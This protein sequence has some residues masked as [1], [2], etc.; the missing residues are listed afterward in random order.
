MRRS[1]VPLLLALALVAVGLVAIRPAVA[2]GQG[3]PAV[4]PGILRLPARDPIRTPAAPLSGTTAVELGHAAADDGA[5][6][7]VLII[8]EDRE[9]PTRA[10]LLALGEQLF[11][12]G[13]VP[14][15]DPLLP[16]S[17][18]APPLALPA[19]RVMR[20]QTLSA[21]GIGERMGSWRL[22]LRLMLAEPRLPDGHPLAP[23]QPAPL[24]AAPIVATVL[25]EARPAAGS[26]PGWPERWAATGRAI[27]QAFLA[28]VTPPGGPRLP[29]RHPGVAWETPL[30]LPP[31]TPELRWQGAF[32]HALLRGW[33]GRIAGRTVRAR[34]GSEEGAEQPLRRLLARGGW[35]PLAPEGGWQLWQRLKDGERQHFGLRDDG[36]GWTAT[37][38]YPHPDPAALIERLGRAAAAGDAGAR[39]RLQRLASAPGLDAALRARLA[40]CMP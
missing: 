36:D 33:V 38:W 10:A 5:W 21:E 37:A 27:A 13:I 22:R 7:T 16:A 8:G 15:L 32:Q 29:E 30:P 1:A 17:E 28:A 18:P 4:H 24:L 19:D 3:G 26:D 40:A 6:R 14:V 20:V 23:L 11:Q 12:A 9:A 25:H 34:D 2:R 39:A 35:E 31:L